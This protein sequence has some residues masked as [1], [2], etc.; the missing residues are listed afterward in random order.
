[1]DGTTGAERLEAATAEAYSHTP[2]RTGVQRTIERAEC[3][4]MLL[5]RLT[6]VRDNPDDRDDQI[7]TLG[8]LVAENYRRADEATSTL[9]AI[10]FA[11]LA[12]QCQSTM[13]H[14]RYGG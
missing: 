9:D 10:H 4:Q 12:R 14:L 3:N 6:R 2:K 5:G 1:M 7:N 11:R 13:D 8:H